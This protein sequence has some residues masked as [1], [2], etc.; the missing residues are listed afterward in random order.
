MA[1]ID[2]RS[3]RTESVDRSRLCAGARTWHALAITAL[4]WMCVAPALVIGVLLVIE[5]AISNSMPQKALRSR[6]EPGPASLRASVP[7]PLRLS[8]VCTQLEP[9]PCVAP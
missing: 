1:H 5:A 7:R 6:L 4:A 3:Y 8:T 2:P 9:A